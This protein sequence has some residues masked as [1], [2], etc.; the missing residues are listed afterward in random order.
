MAY[1]ANSRTR[2]AATA[3]KTVPAKAKRTPK[4][5]PTKPAVPEFATVAEAKAFY[6]GQINEIGQKLHKQAKANRLCDKY[7]KVVN[8]VN[9]ELA[10]SL[11]PVVK[12]QQMAISF[13]ISFPKTGGDI[14]T[15]T[16]SWGETI[17]TEVAS[18]A[19]KAR[20][21]KALT[22][23][24]LSPTESTVRFGSITAEW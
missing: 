6:E 15:K 5:K 23:A 3:A 4:P 8:E 1:A 16:M 22:D 10:V 24:G 13:N 2:S 11:P 9:A 12:T 17:L 21:L 20:L 19:L 14:A 7:E 18:K